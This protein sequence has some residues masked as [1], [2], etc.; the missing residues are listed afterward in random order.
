MSSGSTA[1]GGRLTRATIPPPRRTFEPGRRDR[2][3]DVALGVIAERGIAGASHRA[4]AEAAKVPLGATTYYFNT[5]EDMHEQ[6]FR[7]HAE[8]FLEN[9]RSRL[10]PV[11]A[12]DQFVGVVVDLVMEQL[13]NKADLVPTIELYALAVRK[14]A[15]R[16]IADEW[17]QTMCNLLAM[18]TDAESARAINALTE[19]IVLHG[20]LSETT[21]TR[22]QVYAEVDR[23]VT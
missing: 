15:F 4:V 18:H 13:L 3:I 23:L 14:P 1:S 7:L 9:F 21:F 20:T 12:R 2:L 8:R 11:T 19:G 16:A 10:G 17:V 6:A 22:H 5:L